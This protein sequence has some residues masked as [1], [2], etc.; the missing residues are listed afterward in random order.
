MASIQLSRSAKLINLAH[1]LAQNANCR[2]LRTF[3]PTG[4]VSLDIV[5]TESLPPCAVSEEYLVENLLRNGFQYI[6]KE[7]LLQGYIRAKYDSEFDIWADSR[8]PIEP[9]TRLIIDF[10][11]NFSLSEDIIDDSDLTE[12]MEAFLAR[13]EDA[14]E[15]LEAALRDNREDL[16]RIFGPIP[17]PHSFPW[18]IPHAG[19]RL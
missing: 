6:D 16:Q 4:A 15:C 19:A 12:T 2:A 7:Y 17:L 11:G 9:H 18:T 1:E 14:V 8:D 13:L 5:R 3:A 10:S